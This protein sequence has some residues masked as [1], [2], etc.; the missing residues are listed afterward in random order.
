MT[1]ALTHS[2]D[3]ANAS[4]AEIAIAIQDLT[5]QY[6]NREP[7]LNRLS[8]SL[9]VGQRVGVIGHNGCGKTTLFMLLC[10]VLAPQFRHYLSFKQTD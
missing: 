6:P 9:Q 10:G 8:L 7:V 5:F 3:Q 1:S 2:S 4:R